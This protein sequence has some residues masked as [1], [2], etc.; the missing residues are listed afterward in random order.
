M[1]IHFHDPFLSGLSEG[2]KPRPRMS[3][4]EWAEAYM[5]L[6]PERSASPGPYRVGDATFQRG[7]MDAV[8]DPDIE[9]IVYVTSSQV[10]KT[11]VLMAAQGYYA[12]AEPAPQL[13]V[14]PTQIV[15]D[16]YCSET[17]DTT[18]RDTPALRDIIKNL[19]YPS[20]YIVF[21][22]ANNPAQLAMRPIRVVTGDEVDR[23]PLSAAKEGS[24]V[25]LAK[26]RRATYRNRKGIWCSTPVR[27]DTSQIVE[28]FK[29]TR[30]HYFHV[31]CPDCL[32]S[33]VLKWENV[34]YEKGKEDEATYSCEDCG[35]LWPE[36]LKRRLVREGVWVHLEDSPFE[37]FKTNLKPDT[38]QIGF[39]I[40][41]L[42]SP[43]SSMR[44]MAKSWSESEGNPEKEQTF[45]NT[46][47][48]LP[49]KGDISSF[50]DWSGLL[51]RREKYDPII[52]PRQAGL[53]T[54][55]ADVQDDRI[56]VLFVAWGKGEECWLMQH[57]VIPLDPST[58]RAWEELAMQFERGFAHAGA[59]KVSLMPFATT[60]DS[61]GHF[62]QRAYAFS[63]K[64]MK[65]GRRWHAHRGV[66][67]EKKP[68]WVQSE[69]RFKDNAKLFLIGVDDAKTTI[70]TRY[71]IEKPGPGYIHLHD[72]FD[73]DAVRQMTA[74]RAETEYI[75]GF[76]KRV[77]TKPRHRRN[78]LLD[79]I[80]Y[81]YAVRC[82]LQVDIDAAI[83]E[84]NTA[85]NSRL[86]VLD[87]EAIGKL[88]K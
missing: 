17:F 79:L 43:W 88:Y 23:W 10:G 78:E 45:F 36:M 30:Q 86:P 68:I 52:I 65:V 11:T 49:Y 82:S 83:K 41:E 73:E 70:Y 87:A 27:E 8:T 84:L 2:T 57:V 24:P 55:A 33:Q 56:E 77:W 16:A 81:N 18:V 12:E 46:R 15:A 19:E 76:P 44:E 71:A 6:P 58:D 4:S 26:K 48:G 39:W 31:S 3:L 9:D 75:N 67:G 64:W 13:S 85:P 69:Q 21:V 34:V 53:M 72:K 5:V 60:T 1:S 59:A 74:E 20:G 38:A 22:G 54:A 25:E 37:V 14:F 47:L 42:Y 63:Q 80:A 29:R 40:N 66:P 35:S 62:T 50:A 7:M 28:M 61:G 32:H 51:A